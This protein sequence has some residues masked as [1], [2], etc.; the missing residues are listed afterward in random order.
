MSLRLDSA[1]QAFDATR[2]VGTRLILCDETNAYH[3]WLRMRIVQYIDRMR[4]FQSKAEMK[5][6][7]AL[8]TWF[9]DKN[10]TISAYMKRRPWDLHKPEGW[11]YNIRQRR[12]ASQPV[13]LFL[14][15]AL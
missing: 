12:L 8:S 4:L 5:R 14:Y 3:T 13:R 6:R 15:L 7:I 10:D 9:S 1:A 11:P 2:N